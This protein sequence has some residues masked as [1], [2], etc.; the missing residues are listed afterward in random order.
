LATCIFF[1]L[2]SVAMT[3]ILIHHAIP[4]KMAGEIIDAG[5]L[6]LCLHDPS[7]YQRSFPARIELASSN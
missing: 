6:G 4:F 7:P 5:L 3:K 2:S 1:S